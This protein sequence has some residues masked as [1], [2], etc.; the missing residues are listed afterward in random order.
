MDFRREKLQKVCTLRKIILWEGKEGEK[1]GLVTPKLLTS[2]LQAQ[3]H[4]FL[5]QPTCS[6]LG[7]P[8][9]CRESFNSNSSGDQH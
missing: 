9:S 3:S 6:D 5:K 1:G 4:P 2:T 7:T 8:Q